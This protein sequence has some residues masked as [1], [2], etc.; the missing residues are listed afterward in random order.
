MPNQFNSPEGDIENYF[1]SEY[2]LIDQYIGDTLWVW[3]SNALAR[4][5]TNDAVFK[6]TPVT[7][8]PGGSNWKQISLSQNNFGGIKADGTLWVWGSNNY[9]QLGVN[10]I[11]D[12]STPVQ[13]FA[14]GTD[15]KQV[16]CGIRA[17]YGIKTNGSLWAWGS[18]FVIGTNG[19]GDRRTPVQ[20]FAGGNDWRQVEAGNRQVAAI[21]TDGS[22]WLWGINLNGEVGHNRLTGASEYALT[23]VTTS[24]GGNNWK[25][26]S[27]GDGS[28]AAIKTDGTLWVWGKNTSSQLGLNDT[29]DRSFPV[30]ILGG[31]NN[32]KKVCSGET[33]MAAI[34][35]DGSLWTWGSN[36][37][38]VLGIN[39]VV[40]K[41]TPVQTFGS[42]TNWKDVSIG[43]SS[44][45][46]IKTDGTLWAWGDERYLGIPSPQTG[47]NKL[48]PVTT[49]AGETDWK[50][51]VV[52]HTGI[53]SG[54]IKIG[55][56]LR[57]F[58]T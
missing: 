27:C 14:G 51:V 58:S 50:Q 13:T 30:E 41:S 33:N 36:T 8:L 9:G 46:A 16:S 25:Q 56:D 31:G 44:A 26:V 54:A 57:D 17:T 15:W 45:V 52:S 22:L 7:T 12:R 32:W 1:V 48:T 10:D 20:T 35:N 6:T 39:S 11:V 28:T 5:G 49:F 53:R 38:G 37:T 34:K 19:G 40:N 2:W 23:P 18:S 43:S 42:A 3:G 4:L 21:K 55:F 47:V 24:L 29:N